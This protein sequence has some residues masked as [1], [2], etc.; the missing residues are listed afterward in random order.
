MYSN[1]KDMKPVNISSLI[2]K[3]G[4]GYVAKSKKTGKVI[5]SAKRLDFL[6]KKTKD[7]TNIV[8]SWIPK[9]DARYVF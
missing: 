7:K 3:Y 8:I 9:K 6:F 2:K 1:K 4:P 5:A